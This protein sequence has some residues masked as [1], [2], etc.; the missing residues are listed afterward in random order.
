M[1]RK[2]LFAFVAA[3]LLAPWPV[4]YAYDDVLAMNSPANI[5]SAGEAAAPKMNVFGHAIGGITAGDLFYIDSDNMTADTHYTLY[6][7]NTDELA[8]QY[9]YMNL[10]IGIYLQVDTDQWEEVSWGTDEERHEFYITMQSGMTEFTLPGYAS[11]K[12]TLDNGCFYC[13]GVDENGNVAIPRFYLT[14]T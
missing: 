12:I 1:K 11:Y 10:K 8:G 7:T 2:I 5:E 9:R 3:L 13:Y 14:S 4:A 6:I